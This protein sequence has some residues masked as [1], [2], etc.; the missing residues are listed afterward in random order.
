MIDTLFSLKSQRHSAR[1]DPRPAPQR[2]RDAPQ[3]RHP[4]HGVAS[5]E[6]LERL[7]RLRRAEPRQ[8]DRTADGARNRGPVGCVPIGSIEE[9]PSFEIFMVDIMVMSF[10]LGS[11]VFYWK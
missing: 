11:E 3:E 6:R 2:P 5:H 8:G 10:E 7:G 1:L 4:P 9:D